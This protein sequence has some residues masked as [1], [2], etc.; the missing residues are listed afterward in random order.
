MAI[1][2]VSLPTGAGL[3]LAGDV[4]HFAE[5]DAVDVVGLQ[6]PTR[7]LAQ[8]DN[9]L[10]GKVNEVIQSVNNR[11]QFVPLTL[12]RTTLAPSEE[13]IPFNY[14]IPPGFEARVLNAIVAATPASADA[15]LSV[16]YTTGFGAAAGENLLTTSG[17]FVSGTS[18]KTAGEF[19]ISLKNKG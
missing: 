11:E 17:E 7:Y 3:D 18:F 5:G 4:R 16:Q 19:I 13:L 1:K 12:V 6:N 15:E 8:R 9:L 14:R 2:P 10:A